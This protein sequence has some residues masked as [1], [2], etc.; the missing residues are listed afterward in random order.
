MW[1]RRTKPLIG[2]DIGSHAIKLVRFSPIGGSYQLLNLAMLP[3]P[4]E[5]VVDGVIADIPVIQATLRRLIG[6]EKITDKDVVLALSGHS[7]IV[8]KVQMVRMSEE[9]LANAIPYEAEQHIPFDVYDVNTDFQILDAANAGLGKSGQMEVLLAAAK[10]G[11]VEELSL[12]A[13]GANLTPAVIDVDML[14]LING[15]ELNYPEDSHGHVISLVH[16][17]ASMITVL[18]LKDGLSIF[19]RDS[20]VGGHQYTAALQKALGLNHED[21]EAVKI[22][23]RPWNRAQTDVLTSLRRVT[24]EVIIEI[25]RSFEFYLAS[26]GDEPVEKVYLSGGSSRLKGLSQ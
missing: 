12:V 23:V 14:A 8:K 10:K 7:V 9:E 3:I 5:A 25:Q 2:I 22:G 19:Q 20:T 4:P 17:G 6:L 13:H 26:A 11:R 21:A 15:F 18:I 16:L 1:F 24:E